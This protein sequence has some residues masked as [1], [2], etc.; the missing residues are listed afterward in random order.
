VEA[1]GIRALF[2]SSRSE[3]TLEEFLR[4]MMRPLAATHPD[5][6]NPG[7]FDAISMISLEELVGMPPAT[8]MNIVEQYDSLRNQ[9]TPHDD[10]LNLIDSHRRMSMAAIEGNGDGLEDD[11]SHFPPL[12]DY[13]K[14]VLDREIV[15]LRGLS[16]PLDY[17]RLV[18][19]ETRTFAKTNPKN[20]LL[21]SQHQLREEITR[22]KK[23]TVA[24]SAAKVLVDM[25]TDTAEPDARSLNLKEAALAE[26]HRQAVYLRA[27]TVTVVAMRE[28]Q[29]SEQSHFINIFHDLIKSQHSSMSKHDYQSFCSD[30]SHQTNVY[31][32]F[33]KEA[34]GSSD[35]LFSLIGQAFARFCHKE[36]D[37]GY[38]NAGQSVFAKTIEISRKILA[39]YKGSMLKR[40]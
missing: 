20:T 30:M 40:I 12:T 15:N 4:R 17:I 32:G 9:G 5:S 3:E 34:K 1:M 11:R 24:H 26:F 8:I 35:N 23:L 10:A 7:F 36:R 13:I 28:L 19:Q 21:A 18:I 37:K 2:S 27:F 16:I 22:P 39:E 33:L 38:V 14:E 25:I 29:E 6:C 31:S